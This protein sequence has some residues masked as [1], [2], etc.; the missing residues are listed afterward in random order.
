[1]LV[2]EVKEWKRRNE[3]P[4][5]IVLTLRHWGERPDKMRVYEA[6]WIGREL[7]K[8]GIR[9]VHSHFAGIGARTC[10]WLQEFFDVTYSFTG[11]ANDLFCKVDFDL[12]LDRLMSGASLVVTVSDYTVADLR[13]RFPASASRSAGFTTV[14]IWRRSKRLPGTASM[15]L[16]GI[17]RKGC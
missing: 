13:R 5:A 10:W 1:M 12:T 14:W 6:A 4:Q 15:R 2:E 17:L 7:T 8:R 16:S 9:H 3:L 11:H